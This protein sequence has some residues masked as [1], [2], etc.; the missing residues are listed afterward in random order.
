MEDIVTTEH[1]VAEGKYGEAFKTYREHAELH[2]QAVRDYAVMLGLDIDTLDD[3]TL[4]EIYYGSQFHDLGM[5][6]GGVD[7]NGRAYGMAYDKKHQFAGYLD[8]V[9]PGDGFTARKNHP[10][11]SAVAVLTTDLVPEGLDRDKIALLALS[12]SKS[13]SGVT[14]FADTTQ[15]LAAIDELEDAVNQYNIKNGLTGTSAIQFDADRLR[16]LVSDP[17]SAAF[18]EL[19]DQALCIR[20]GDAMSDLALDSGGHTI[21]QTGTVAHIDSPSLPYDTKISMDD[22]LASISDVVKTKDG[23]VLFEVE[24]PMGKLFHAG[25]ENVNFD[26]VYDGKS[27]V[28]RVELKDPHKVPNSS[29]FAITERLGEGVT[30]TNCERRFIVELPSDM[31]HTEMGDI[32]VETI[33]KEAGSKIAKATADLEQAKIDLSTGKI[34]Q[35]AFNQIEINTEN[36]VDFYSH[37]IEVT[38]YG[39]IGY[40]PKTAK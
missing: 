24:D 25:E 18:K 8:D 16:G 36:I 5:E 30:Y 11:N 19:T 12:H 14:S 4:A 26:S 15:W 40:T 27:Y 13:T 23:E 37:D 33:K 2:T 7:A 6:G 9:S 21:M 3:R 29:A 1:D 10:L 35:E 17:N 22:E 32:Y 38:G 20:D 34:T 31:A 39:V 28:G